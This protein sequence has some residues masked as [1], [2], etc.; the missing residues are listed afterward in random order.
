MGL[1]PSFNG[2]LDNDVLPEAIL[3]RNIIDDSLA[4]IILIRNLF[5]SDVANIPDLDTS[6]RNKIKD[7][8]ECSE[9]V[10]KE[11]L[12]H[13][14]DQYDA[15]TDDSH[16][17]RSLR[18]RRRTKSLTKW[19][20][21]QQRETASESF[22]TKAKD[23]LLHCHND[24]RLLMSL[25]DALPSKESNE[26]IELFKKFRDFAVGRVLTPFGTHVQEV[27][28][29]MVSI[30]LKAKFDKQVDK[31]KM[32]LTEIQKQKDLK[33]KQV[34]DERSLLEGELEII[35]NHSQE[36]IANH[37]GQVHARLKV[38]AWHSHGRQSKTLDHILDL[39]K[40]LQEC[41]DEHVLAESEMRKANAKLEKEVKDLIDKYDLE[42]FKKH[43]TIDT[44][45]KEYETETENL[46]E[47]LKVLAEVEDQQ[48][49]LMEQNR[50]EEETRRLLELMNIR[51]IVA[52][53]TI[54]RAYRSHK[55]RMMLKKKKR[56]KK[57]AAKKG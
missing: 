26:F 21:T 50:V 24:K 48:H 35:R 51:R 47:L 19:K 14:L 46:D 11:D 41:L 38:L 5:E 32:D 39:K 34:N 2:D 49:E 18:R 42:M 54:Q 40:E 27:E 7:L 44:I 22:V 57:S 33:M 17:T 56:K 28:S 8:Q 3:I 37:K 31:L 43:E 15:D 25:K 30:N 36:L 23:I 4:N 13:Q 53:K 6:L 45:T 12:A 16:E 1:M 52:A 9:Q 55:T 20:T 29:L 10:L